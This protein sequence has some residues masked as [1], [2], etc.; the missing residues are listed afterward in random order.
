MSMD[1]SAVEYTPFEDRLHTC[2]GDMLVYKSSQNTKFFA[3]QSMPSF[4]RDWLMMRFSDAEGRIQNEKIAQYV[5]KTIPSK[6]QWSGIMLDMLHGNRDVRFLTKVKIEF[7]TKKKQALFSLPVFG[8]PAH[9]GEAVANWDVLEKNRDELLSA[10]ESWGIV[11]V[12]CEPD[13]D[14]KNNILKL[15]DFKPF[16]PYKIYLDYYIRARDFF[17]LEEWIDILLGAA[18]YNAGGYRSQKEKLAMLKRLMPFVE[19]RLNLVELAPKETGKSYL[20]SQVSQYGWLISGGSVSRAKMFYDIS[21]RTNGLVSHNDYVALDEVQSIKFTEPMEMRGALKGYL[22]SG[23]YRVGDYRGTGNA[24][25]ILLGNIDADQMDTDTDMFSKLP[26]FFHESALLDR[27]H[28]F[29]TGWEIPKMRESLKADGWA[30]N[31][32]YFV[33]I[34]HALRGENI[35]RSVVDKLLR[36]PPD[37]ATRD[38]EAVK[39]LC[40][41]FLKLLFPNATD[42]EKVNLD[43]FEEYCLEPALEM[44]GIIKKQLSIIDP[45]E[46]GGAKMPDITINVGGEEKT[47]VS[48]GKREET[49]D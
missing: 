38:T 45:G 23:E 47:G 37:A 17:N 39:R 15:I 48:D 31:T 12:R 20:F 22:E 8:V 1:I 3:D 21:K 7:D 41:A 24:G 9:K 43:E 18:D 46:F 14:N 4:I 19:K 5:K 30:L 49:E 10:S 11:T 32:E 34:L 35:Y 25:L 28:G 42:V 33:E 6:E 40:T 2:F 44:R 26:A 27:F 13:D 36:L 29:I 16:C